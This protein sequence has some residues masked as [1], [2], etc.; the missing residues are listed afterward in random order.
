M[1]ISLKTHLREN[2]EAKGLPFIQTTQALRSGHLVKFISADE[3]DAITKKTAELPRDIFA[4]KDL[5]D[6]NMERYFVQ[7]LEVKSE[8]SALVIA[9]KERNKEKALELTE[10]ESSNDLSQIF[11]EIITDEDLGLFKIGRAHV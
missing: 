10:L 11:L 8:D 5:N 4:L 7:G 1:L 3:R 2:Q 9:I 6:T